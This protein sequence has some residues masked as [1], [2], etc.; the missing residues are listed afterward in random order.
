MYLQLEVKTI[1]NGQ[2]S[3]ALQWLSQLHGLMTRNEGFID[4]RSSQFLGN[5]GQ[6]LVGRTWLNAEA[7][8]AYRATP[9]A[10]AFTGGPMPY[11]NLLVQRWD[12]LMCSIGDAQGNFLVRTI[13]KIRSGSWDEYLENRRRYDTLS[14]REG[15][16]VDVR[17]YRL[18]ASGSGG[19]EALVLERRHSRDG[20]DRL[21]ES[22][23]Y[24]EY[25]KALSPGLYSTELTE[26]Y[27]VIQETN[28]DALE[29]N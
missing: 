13:H 2:L 11:K 6:Y 4:A 7:H 3:E 23:D 21:L 24:I 22:S 5:P 17:T 8:Q 27:E 28:I 10:I 25:E 9:E 19:T 1:A 16:V 15:G 20:Y 29:G 14:L 18:L 12:E 26:C